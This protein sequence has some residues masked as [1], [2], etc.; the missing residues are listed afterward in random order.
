VV[1]RRHQASAAHSRDLG[2]LV[3]WIAADALSRDLRVAGSLEPL[4][5]RCHK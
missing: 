1:A 4:C 2:E 3:Q 5:G